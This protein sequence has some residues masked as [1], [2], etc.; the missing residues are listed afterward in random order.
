MSPTLFAREEGGCTL[1]GDDLDIVTF[2]T[3]ANEDNWIKKATQPLSR[4]S[5][6]ACRSWGHRKRRDGCGN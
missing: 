6:A 5:G 3:T 2:S 1:N 4:H